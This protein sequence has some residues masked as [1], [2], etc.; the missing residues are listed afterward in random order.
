[1]SVGGVLL[2]PQVAGFVA[3]GSLLI[4]VGAVY[5]F[6][7]RNRPMQRHPPRSDDVS[8]RE[9]WPLIEW[10][11][12]NGNQRIPT[13]RWGNIAFIV[14]FGIFVLLIAWTLVL[15]IDET[16][17]FPSWSR[18]LFLLAILWFIAYSI[19]LRRL[20]RRWGDYWPRR[21]SPLPASGALH[22]PTDR[23]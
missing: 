1:M 2:T 10:S 20:R 4:V 14:P 3:L 5:F 12:V 15:G 19:Y 18:W 17:A 8:L 22:S 21:W 11:M 7:Q 9:R 13:S 6:S 16:S 23:I